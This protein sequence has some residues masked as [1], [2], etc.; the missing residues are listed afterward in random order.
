[1]TGLRAPKEITPTSAPQEDIN[2]GGSVVTSG[3]FWPDIKLADLRRAMRLDGTVTTDR[4][5]HAASEA[6]LNANSQLDAWRE[7]QEAD[8]FVSLMTVPAPAINGTTALVFRYHRA[9]YC[10]AKALLTEGYRD[11]DTTRQGEKH[12]QALSTQID[13]LWRDGQ[14]AIRD[15]LGRHRMIAEL[16]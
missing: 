16:V 13:D 5:M 7:K 9:V 8:G 10:F 15:I 4:L 1:M 12:A 11:I 2:D 14:H 3:A 6:A